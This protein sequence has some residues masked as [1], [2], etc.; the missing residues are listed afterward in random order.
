MN[1]SLTTVLG[2]LMQMSSSHKSHALSSE[3]K[4]WV[5][6]ASETVIAQLTPLIDYQSQ[7][8]NHRL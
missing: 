3:T 8:L 6:V 5:L 1:K 4:P 7:G 2:N